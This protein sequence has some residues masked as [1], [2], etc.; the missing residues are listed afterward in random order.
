MTDHVPQLTP[1]MLDRFRAALA[2]A[3]APLADAIGPGITDAQ[4]D[5]LAGKL[6]LKAPPELRT[7]WT[8][9]AVTQQPASPDSWD[10]NVEFAL[11]PPQ[12][13]IRET[14]EHRK[15]DPTDSRQTI[16]FGGSSGDQLLV[17]GDPTATRSPVTYALL[18]SPN[19]IDAGPSLG[20]LFE[21]WTTQL[22]NGDYRYTDGQWHPINGPM[23]FIPSQ[24]G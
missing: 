15:L 18:E 3:G 22:E 19:T 2:T 5:K 24:S 7:L 4:V 16:S 23:V 14:K 6:G 20:A 10:I 21:L 9:G 12:V 13:A 17:E 11:W 8:W 1:E